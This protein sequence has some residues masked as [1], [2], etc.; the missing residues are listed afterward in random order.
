VGESIIGLNDREL[1]LRVTKGDGIAF[2]VLFDR[3]VD[4]VYNHCFRRTA[5][6]SSAEDLTSLVWL[7]TWRRRKDVKIFDESILPWLLATANNCLRNFNR[8]RRRHRK[9]LNRLPPVQSLADFGDEAAR[10]MDD[11]SEM[12]RILSALSLLRPEEQEV[13][14][15]CDW[16]GLSYQAAAAAIGKPVGT[17]KSR[18][19]RAH[20]HLRDTLMRVEDPDPVSAVAAAPPLIEERGTQL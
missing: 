19:S 18:L 15:L 10:R 13:V 11:E 12:S 6:W 8:S 7:E 3:H 4:S 1:W 20:G 9:Y 17:V 16:S 14:A 2:G 5:S